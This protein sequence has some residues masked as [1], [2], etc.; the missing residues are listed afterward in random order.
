MTGGTNTQA[1]DTANQSSQTKTGTWKHYE[2]LRK[3]NPKEYYKP[4]TQNALMK[5]RT[6]MGY[7]A[8]NS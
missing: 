1:I 5:S 3:S 4:A 7:E 6:D 8:F 2:E